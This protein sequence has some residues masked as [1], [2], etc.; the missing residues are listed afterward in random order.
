LLLLILYDVHPSG[1]KIE[2]VEGLPVESLLR[3]DMA[4]VRYFH[5]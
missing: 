4:S 5:G 2:S 3:E 1:N